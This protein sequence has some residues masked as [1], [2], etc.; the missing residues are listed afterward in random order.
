M[1]LC[2]P[3]SEIYSTNEYNSIML[4]DEKRDQIASILIRY[5]NYDQ[6]IMKDL[7]F[8]LPRCDP[9]DFK[10]FRDGKIDLRQL[11]NKVLGIP[12]D[13]IVN[14]DDINGKCDPKVDN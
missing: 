5:N 14:M 10:R 3:N 1:D 9:M 2:V 13:F 4:D 11:R 6:K 8:C 7:I 12:D